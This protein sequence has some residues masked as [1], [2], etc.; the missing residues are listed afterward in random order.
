[1][2]CVAVVVAVAAT[3]GLFNSVRAATTERVVSDWRTGLALFGFDPVAYFTDAAPLQGNGN[4]EYSYAGV[5]WRFRNLGNRAAFVDRPDVYMPRFG[6]YDPVAIARGVA[7]A[8]S[9]Q[10][11]QIVDQRLYVF[12]TQSAQAAF[13]KDPKHAIG[14]ADGRWPDVIKT[15]SP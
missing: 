5:I 10:Y 9:P 11:W 14:V 4:F 1:M 12:S 2:G 13:A 15:L 8:G 7:V 6:G 3:A